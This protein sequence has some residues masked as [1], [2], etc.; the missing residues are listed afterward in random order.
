M[1]IEEN[2]RVAFNGLIDHKVRSFLTM[3]G[4]IFGVASVIAMLSI[5]EGAK[6]EAI[7][8]FQQ[9]GVNN[10][11]IRDKDLSDEELE[12]ARAKFS[13]GLSLEDV[14]AIKNIVPQVENIAPQ[15]EKSSDVKY[16]DKSVKSNLIGIT[17]EF[18]KILN[19]TTELGSFITQDHYDRQLKVCVIGSDIAAKFFYVNDPIG[20]S[21]KIDDQW[22]EVIGVLKSKSLFTETVG[23]LASRDL[24]SDIYI[25]LSTFN[26]RFEKEKELASELKQI[27]VKVK[28]SKNIT[29]IA[30][31]IE[32][33][34]SRHHFENQ[35]FSIV[36][37]VE[38]LKQEEKER[39]IYNILLGSIAA[40]SLLVGGIGIMNIMLATVMERT[41][42][43]GV[44]RAIGAKRDAILSQFITEA[45]VISIT[46]GIIGVLFGL[47]LSLS[48]T[49]FTEITTSV[50][51]YSVVI[52]FLFSVIVGVTFGYLPAKKAANLRPIESIRYE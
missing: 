43:I 16:Q 9:L 36:I 29:K 38:L 17:P 35:D 41:R 20:Q 6:R 7:K 10:I 14:E 22:L 11:I 2:L 48:I 52:A 42:E 49:L 15:A 34:V 32:N 1:Q 4:I 27:T 28:D 44:R 39:R 21:I 8:K 5:G 37:P 51:L 23:E 3:L 33:L 30:E 47:S 12:T 26:G 25:P 31:I 40:I 45:L 50:T 13:Q 19:Y 46:G 24:N 18:S